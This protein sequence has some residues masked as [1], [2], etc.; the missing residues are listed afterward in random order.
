LLER[1]SVRSRLHALFVFV[2]GFSLVALAAACGSSGD[3]G[4]SEDEVSAVRQAQ[5]AT[6]VF[7]KL[8]GRDPSAAEIARLRNATL[9]Q[10][11]DA[12]LA[13][14]DYE[15]DGFYAFQ[16]DRLLL[17]RDGDANW[18]DASVRDYC[19]LRLDMQDV[20]KADAT[21]AGYYEI[22]KYRERWVPVSSGTLGAPLSCFTMK[23]SE[24]RRAID[25]QPTW[26]PPPPPPFDGG[27]DGSDGI[28]ASTGAADAGA[29]TDPPA[30]ISP[31]AQTC[32]QYM[33]F[34]EPFATELRALGADE[35]EKPLGDT[36]PAKS[37]VAT[38]LKQSTFY[39]PPGVEAGEI[40]IAEGEG[41]RMPIR[42]FDG[43]PDDRC[44]TTDGYAATG[45]GAVTEGFVRVRVPPALEGVH[46]S[47]YW[48]SRHP[49]TQKN[50]DLHR[51][52]LVFF[53]YMCTEISPAQAA[54]GGGEPVHIDALREYFAADDQHVNTSAN[55]YNCH[56]QVQPIANYFGEL[57]KGVPYE[58]NGGFGGGSSGG[59]GFGFGGFYHQGDGFRR[60][61]GLW[62]GTE[63][64]PAG[65]G[66][67]GMEGLAELLPSLESSN[68]CIVKNAW[69][70]LVGTGYP[71]S[72]E[73]RG[74]AVTAFKGDGTFRFARLLR[75]LSTENPR[76][77]AFFEKGENGLAAAPVE[78]PE[79]IDVASVPDHAADTPASL[80]V[81]SCS[82][83]HSGSGNRAF[84]ENGAW[85]PE[86]LVTEPGQPPRRWAHLAQLYDKAYCKV[87]SD[88]MPMGGWDESGGLSVADKKKKALCF[89]SGKRNEL[90]RA[91][92]DPAIKAL[93]SRPCDGQTPPPGRAPH[94]VPPP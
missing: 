36:A 52:R 88:S 77:K 43:A 15:K 82:G 65:A 57:S 93:D 84:F 35:A 60:P 86:R 10:M 58:Q 34:R 19:A 11:V 49:S 13:L 27:V 78:S 45:P 46:A 21:G 61:G 9:P 48:L 23:A 20:A 87:W 56:T 40:A 47:T 38:M 6:R 14:P 24:I 31:E 4:T 64:H 79:C 7:R 30:P 12:V 71:L 89:F 28:D 22:L 1:R 62:K 72:D 67:F 18:M 42:V 25:E 80:L 75:H 8:V 85:K 29:E 32:A 74:A 16:R 83:C 73:E 41:G 66:K 63:F 54:I 68:D 37:L 5:M 92:D 81:D 55:C 51:A 39:A 17:H 91:S 69:S 26:P 33:R 76:G 90:A 70:T 44:K 59:F 53:S 3:E 50:R 2:A 94:P